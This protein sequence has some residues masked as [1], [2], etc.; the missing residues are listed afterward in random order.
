MAGFDPKTMIHRGVQKKARK[1]I[2]YGPPKLGKSTLVGSTKGALMIPTEDRV[3]HIECDKTP[4]VS[5]LE[6]VLEVFEYLMSDNN[7]EKGKRKYTRVIL[8]TLD[9]FEP[10]LHEYVC[11]KKNFKSLTDDHNKETAFS[12]G[13]KYHAVAGWKFFLQYCDQLRDDGI[14]VIFVAHAQSVKFNPPDTDEYD[15]WVMKVDKHSLAVLEEWADII[16]FYNKEI[17]VRKGEGMNKAKGKITTSNR[18]LLHL[19]GENAAMTSGNSFGLPDVEVILEYA[20]EIMEWLLTE[21]GSKVAPHNE[22]DGEE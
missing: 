17:F 5:T 2:I 12:K 6:E 4:V 20:S 11:R 13:L 22:P 16:G 18:R 14:D 3:S 15:K 8:D 21:N 10:V 7:M 19:A 1:I 9:W